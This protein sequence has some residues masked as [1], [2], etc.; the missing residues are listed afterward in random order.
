MKRNHFVGLALSVSVF[1]PAFALAGGG[2]TFDVTAP[3]GLIPTLGSQTSG[4][5]VFPLVLRDTNSQ[6][7]PQIT[8]LELALNGL[9]HTN[10][11]DL[12]IY[13]IDPFGRTLEVMTDRGDQVAVVELDMVFNDL[14]PA[15][16][17]ESSQIFPGTY[18]AEGAGGLGNFVG[19]SGGTDAWILLV[20]D[21]SEGNQGSMDSW[22][23]RGTGVPE[24]VSLSLLAI[25]GLAA[26]RRRT[27]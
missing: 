19:G 21:D 2:V 13:L 17:P 3:A 16:P 22:T 6:I 26:L 9:T 1:C 10:P 23:L 27:R 15:L 20:I 24:P 18:R 11:W 12:D 25:G 14:A 4:I 8:S 5:S 7:I